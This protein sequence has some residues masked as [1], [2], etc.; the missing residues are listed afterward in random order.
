MIVVLD[1]YYY[2]PAIVDLQERVGSLYTTISLGVEVAM[3]RWTRKVCME[4]GRMY[5]VYI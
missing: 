1:R 2:S 5:L 4:G 3:K